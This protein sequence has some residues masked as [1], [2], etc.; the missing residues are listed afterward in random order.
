MGLLLNN[1]FLGGLLLDGLLL[2]VVI[3]FCFRFG[4]R[5]RRLRLTWNYFFGFQ[6]KSARLL[7]FLWFLNWLRCGFD[8]RLCW[9]RLCWFRFSSR[10]FTSS[11]ARGRRHA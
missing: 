5:G 3:L 10:L 7:R 6:S 8:F 11:S 4:G 9:F 1:F 2:H